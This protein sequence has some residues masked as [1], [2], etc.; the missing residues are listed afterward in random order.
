MAK[1]VPHYNPEVRVSFDVDETLVRFENE[2]LIKHEAHIK[3]LK[4]HWYRGHHVR[5]HSKGGGAW[6]EYIVKKLGLEDFVH[7][8]VA[9]DSWY[10]DDKKA[11][12]W[13]EHYYIPEGGFNGCITGSDEEATRDSQTSLGIPSIAARGSSVI[14]PL[15]EVQGFGCTI[16]SK[17]S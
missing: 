8:S 15:P 13:M 4:L 3:A 14:Y 5:V 10:I 17:T 7:E 12:A 9:K 1:I 11:D 16:T 6:A 2:I